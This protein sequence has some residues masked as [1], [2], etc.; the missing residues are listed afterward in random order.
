MRIELRVTAAQTVNKAHCALFQLLIF[1]AS[2][3]FKGRFH[4]SAFDGFV[5]DLMKTACYLDE[6]KSPNPPLCWVPMMPL[7]PVAVV[8]L[9][10]VVEVVVAFAVSEQG[11]QG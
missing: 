9:E 10:G 3:C 8:R 11:K 2:T 7:V 6:G 1:N 4:L 5:R